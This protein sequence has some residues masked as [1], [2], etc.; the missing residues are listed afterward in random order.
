M[1]YGEDL[2]KQK[3]KSIGGSLEGGYKTGGVF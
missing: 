2:Q 3:T 1:E